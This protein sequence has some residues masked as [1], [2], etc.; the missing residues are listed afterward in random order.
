M[1]ALDLARRVRA[2][3]TPRL[4]WT[5]FAYGRDASGRYAIASSDRACAW[6]LSGA[7]VAECAKE[8]RFSATLAHANMEFYDALK[9][10]IGTGAVDWNDAE[11]R[12]HGDVLAALDRT[13]A[14]LEAA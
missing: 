1:T 9:T 12:T 13:I 11:D 14:A 6:C 2:R 5:Q 7:V 8:W 10:E 4:A 3:L